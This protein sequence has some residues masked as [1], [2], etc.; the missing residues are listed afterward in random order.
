MDT[1]Y[2]SA[3]GARVS[4]GTCAEKIQRL[5]YGTQTWYA[6]SKTHDDSIPVVSAPECIRPTRRVSECEKKTEDGTD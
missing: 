5:D 2:M 6:V 1:F 4:L 3:R